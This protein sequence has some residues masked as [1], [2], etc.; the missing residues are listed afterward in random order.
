MWNKQNANHTACTVEGLF[1]LLTLNSTDAQ[2]L[3]PSLDVLY[4][5]H[6]MGLGDTT[7]GENL[8]NRAKAPHSTLHN[9]VS[10]GTPG[11][12]GPESAY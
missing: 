11:T 9:Q 1:G 4:T 6:D 5:I 2:H 10:K 7:I 12:F 3:N 8:V